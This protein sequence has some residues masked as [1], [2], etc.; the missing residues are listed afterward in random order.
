M[1]QIEIWDWQNVRASKFQYIVLACQETLCKRQ[2]LSHHS[3]PKVWAWRRIRNLFSTSCTHASQ[4]TNYF[5]IPATMDLQNTLQVERMDDRVLQ[6]QSCYDNPSSHTLPLVVRLHLQASDL[7]NRN[8]L[9]RTNV[10][11][12][13]FRRDFDTHCQ[14]KDRHWHGQIG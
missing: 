13:W 3:S 2:R 9:N 12:H 11:T 4:K 7:L 6:K 8:T 10:W 1:N 14:Q 5:V